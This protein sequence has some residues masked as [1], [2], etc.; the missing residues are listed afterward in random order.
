MV[1]LPRSRPK[2][3]NEGPDLSVPEGSLPVFVP[4]SLSPQVSLGSGEGPYHCLE[5]PKTPIGLQRGSKSWDDNVD[6]TRHRVS[7]HLRHV[8][9][10]RSGS[11]ATTR[12][13]PRFEGPIGTL[14]IGSVGLQIGLEWTIG[15]VSIGPVGLQMRLEG[16]IGPIFVVY[17]GLQILRSVLRF[18]LF[19]PRD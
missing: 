2:D 15:P 17:V 5:G 7:H 11:P 1:D 16:P 19:R 8:E 3:V 14:S 10:S 6:T 9:R 4:Q 13:V 18:T 12:T